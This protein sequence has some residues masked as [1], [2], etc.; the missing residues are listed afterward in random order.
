MGRIS[1]RIKALS[2]H[3]CNLIDRSFLEETIAQSTKP[4]ESF[5][6]IRRAIYGWIVMIIL[7]AIVAGASIRPPEAV[8]TLAGERVFSSSRAMDLVDEIAQRPHPVGSIDHERVM[9]ALFYRMS[10]LQLNPIIETHTGYSVS[11]RFIRTAQ[12][13]NLIGT[14]PGTA[15]TKPVVLVAHYDTVEGAPGAGDDAGGVS[16]ILE[17]IRVL[18]LGPRLKNDIIVLLTDGEELGSLGAQMAAQHD[19]WLQRAGI[20][21]NFEGRGD[22]GPSFLFETSAG[23][24]TLVRTFA[25]MVPTPSGSS[26]FYSLYKIMPNET[27][28]TVFRKLGL[29]G[30]NMAWVGRFEAYHSPLD[31]PANLDQRSLQQDGNYAVVLSR[32]FGNLDLNHSRLQERIDAVFFNWFGMHMVQYSRV[33]VLP[34]FLLQ[35]VLM[36]VILAVAFG[37]GTLIITKVFLGSIGAFSM[38]L[39]SMLASWIAFFSLASILR[40]EFLIGDAPSNVILLLGMLLIGCGATAIPFQLL[41]F[42]VGIANLCAGGLLLTWLFTL[43]LTIILPGGSYVVFWPLFFSTVIYGCYHLLLVKSTRAEVWLPA[44]ICTLFFAPTIYQ[45]FLAIQLSNFLALLCGLLLGLGCALLIPLVDVLFPEIPPTFSIGAIVSVGIVTLLVGIVMSR[46]SPRHPLAD[47]VNYRLDGDS[48]YAEWISY[49]HQIDPWTGIMLGHLPTRKVLS[50]PW[51]TQMMGL[52]NI[53]KAVAP[54]LP[55]PRI[56][57]ENN[58]SVAGVRTLY[59]HV[60]SVRQAEWLRMSLPAQA[61]VIAAT[62]NGETIPIKPSGPGNLSLVPWIFDFYGYEDQG[63]ELMLQIDSKVCSAILSDNSAGLPQF[64]PPRPTD[65]IAWDGSDRT[66]VSRRI[67]FC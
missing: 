11:G 24:R 51:G 26:L 21:L 27:D 34:L 53:S 58:S 17:A 29:V 31:T 62:A 57:I 1:A 9:N 65:R 23:N 66:I 4:S 60:D 3:C 33:A 16:A 52:A 67:S 41:R 42:K 15:S 59:F 44:L 19:P 61:N 43:L 2:T 47:S 8:N 13:S 20:I 48:G 64:A 39:T 32:S 18:K 37:K 49:D 35:T 5:L 25:K 36:I 22:S 50:T 10:Q 14:L 54:A 63:V 55:L 40:N 6:V 7:I 12:V 56:T 28:Y 38:V 46:P 45:L 30:M